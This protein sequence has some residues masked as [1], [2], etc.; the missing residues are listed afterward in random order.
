[1]SSDTTKV[2]LIQEKQNLSL[3]DIKPFSS[4]KNDIL[5]D[6]NIF[7]TS[8]KEDAKLILN[9]EGHPVLHGF[10]DAYRNHRPV[11]ISP[12]I[13]W[14]LIL[15]AFSN[16]I[17]NFP[18]KFRSR[19][20]KFEGQIEIKIDSRDKV[21]D[22][23]TIDDWNAEFP[24]FTEEIKKHVGE[25]VIQVLTPDFSTTTETSR[26]V[27]QISI[28][29]AFQHYF[30]YIHML[31]I[32]DFPFVNVE[33]TVDDWE[34]ILL[35]LDFIEKYD[36]EFWVKKIKPIITKI[37]NTKRGDI[38]REFWL[39]MIQIKEIAGPCG[40]DILNIDGW[41]KEFFPFDTS[42]YY[43]NK[44][45]NILT[46]VENELLSCPVKIELYLGDVLVDVIH[47]EYVSGFIGLTQNPNDSSLKPEI[48]WFLRK[49]VSD[50][51]EIPHRPPLVTEEMRS[52][53]IPK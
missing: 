53:S 20:V 3:I 30:K 6:K 39:N 29:S 33:G 41:F 38:D 34:K 36:F 35:R 19:F 31:G 50:T 42:G 2:N 40:D 25:E 44:P 51:E 43:I 24:K 23:M 1:M 52:Q 7:K 37:I 13:I 28:M 32:C 21:F 26:A 14:L 15:Q 22:N 9:Y 17:Q 48:G 27:G 47:S 16:Y 46:K 49:R 12:D 4:S 11:T 5:S 8:I 45:L 18:D 10:I